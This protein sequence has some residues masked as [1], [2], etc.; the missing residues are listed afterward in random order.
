M[1]K[2]QCSSK[3]FYNYSQSNV[4]IMQNEENDVLADNTP[5]KNKIV[6]RC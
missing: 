6:S 1:L 2:S 5:K 3:M 4:K